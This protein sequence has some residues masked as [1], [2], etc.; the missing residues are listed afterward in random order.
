[1]HKIA[2]A[3]F[4]VGVLLAALAPANA[5]ERHLPGMKGA[6][7]TRCPLQSMRGALR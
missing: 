5:V 2:L 4:G 6:P 7:S 1:M 3:G